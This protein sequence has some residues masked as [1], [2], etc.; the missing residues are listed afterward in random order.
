MK[1]LFL[2]NKDI[3]QYKKIIIYGA[4]IA[5]KTLL[6]KLLQCNI[7]VDCFVDTNPSVCGKKYLNIPVFHINDVLDKREDTAIIVGGW[8][9]AEIVPELERLGFQ[10]IF[11][12]PAGPGYLYLSGDID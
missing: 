5:G 4:G 7:K 12:D 3:F 1:N 8:Y 11:K 6:M 9:I 10:N 2:L